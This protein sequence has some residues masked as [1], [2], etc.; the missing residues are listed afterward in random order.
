MSMA[1]SGEAMGKDRTLCMWLEEADPAVSLTIRPVVKWAEVVWSRAMD[2]E[3]MV[4]AWRKASARLATTGT[5]AW[6]A[7][8]GP[9]EA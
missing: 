9:A 7:V 5:V 8:R 3:A 1:L 2:E 6:S 4:A